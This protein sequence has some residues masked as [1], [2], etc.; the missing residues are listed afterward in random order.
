MLVPWYG[1]GRLAA[2]LG[3]Q[4]LSVQAGFLLVLFLVGNRSATQSGGFL[5]L[6][7]LHLRPP[8]LSGYGMQLLWLSPHFVGSQKIGGR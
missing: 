8:P 2:S 4:G 3:K 5:D 6:W 1:I 7:P